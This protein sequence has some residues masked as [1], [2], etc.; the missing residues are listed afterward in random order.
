M[1]PRLSPVILFFRLLIAIALLFSLLWT[2]VSVQALPYV[3]V[4]PAGSGVTCSQV[5]PCNLATG[6][7]LIDPNGTLYA[8]AGTY[9]GSGNQVVLLD[10]TIYFLGGWDGSP[11]EDVVRDPAAYV[12]IL[13]GQNERRVI[14]VSGSPAVTPIIDGWTIRNGNASGLISQCHSFGATAGCGGGIYAFEAQPTITHNIIETNTAAVAGGNLFG[15]G[16][17]VYIDNSAY[18]VISGNIIRNNNSHKEGVGVGGGIY[19]YNSGIAID[20]SENEIYE[21]DDYAATTFYNHSGTGMHIHNNSGPIQV[22]DNFVYNNNPLDEAYGGTVNLST[23]SNS[24]VLEGNTITDNYGMW[25]VVELNYSVAMIRQ[26]TIINPGAQNGLFIFDTSAHFGTQAASIQNN[27][28]AG[29]QDKN[30]FIQAYDDHDTRVQ[31]S[32][33][34]LADAPY[35]LYIGA[36]DVIVVV[37]FDRGITSGHNLTGIYSSGNPGI[38]VTVTNSLFDANGLDCSPSILNVDP[39][40]GDPWFT[41]PSANNY[42]LRHGSAAID[43]V[44]SG[45]LAVDIDGDPRP[46]GIGTLAY[47]VGADEFIFSD[48]QFLPITQRP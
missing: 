26:N 12:S 10:K 11:I 24:V 20:V 42:H 21:N 5:A 31:L 40:T 8:A 13:D 32:H 36:N 23:C 7:S 44:A 6:L 29:H 16:G 1:K 48:F 47:D 3:F 39:L 37:T 17:G 9:T 25:G 33:N 19:V 34:T 28:I 45:G 30:V 15:A 46:F 18:A 35:G 43:R 4:T 27:I 14:T 2:N 22:R 41:D 38:S